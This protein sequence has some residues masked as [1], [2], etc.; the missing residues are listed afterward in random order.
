MANT[1]YKRPFISRPQSWAEDIGARMP[2]GRL[3]TSG[4]MWW[5][6]APFWFHR[7]RK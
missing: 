5:N 7:R 3:I 4:M 1:N 2:F 6:S